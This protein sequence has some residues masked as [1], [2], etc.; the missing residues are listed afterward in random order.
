[1]S[2]ISLIVGDDGTRGE[3]RLHC[4]FSE[5]SLGVYFFVVVDVFIGQRC[6]VLLVDGF[7]VVLIHQG[8]VHGCSPFGLP[9]GVPCFRG[10]R[11]GRIVLLGFGS[12]SSSHSWGCRFGGGCFRLYSFINVFIVGVLIVVGV[13]FSL[14]IGIVFILVGVLG[15]WSI[16]DGGVTVGAVVL[17]VVVGCPGVGHDQQLLDVALKDFL[18]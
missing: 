8:V 11:G 7:I 15:L 10:R 2:S 14:P 17:T 18:I 6:E 1:M 5:P 12:L 9:A 4:I 13:P 16:G 3:L